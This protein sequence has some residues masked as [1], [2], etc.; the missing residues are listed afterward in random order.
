MTDIPTRLVQAAARALIEHR[1]DVWAS[2]ITLI[3]EAWSCTCG[4]G[5]P[6]ATREAGEAAAS[7]HIAAAP[8]AAVFAE[9]EIREQWGYRALP[10]GQDFWASTREFAEDA[11]KA[12]PT[13]GLQRVLIRRLVIMTPGEGEGE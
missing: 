1:G 8:L 13:Y 4:A 5:E 2:N 6:V 11:V 7:A 10:S 9:C 3:V 12:G